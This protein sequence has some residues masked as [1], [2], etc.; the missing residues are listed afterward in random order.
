MIEGIHVLENI[1]S[2]GKQDILE[3]Y[4]KGTTVKWK[5]VNNL[6]YFK[7]VKSPQSVI[8]SD[9]IKNKVIIN[10]IE[11]IKNNA[12]VRLGLKELQSYRAKVNKLTANKQYSQFNNKVSMHIDRDIKHVS[13]VYYISNAD[14]DTKFYNLLNGNIQNFVEYVKNKEFNRFQEIRAITP[15]KGSI[16]IFDGYTPHHS[17]YPTVTDRYVINYNVVPDLTSKTLI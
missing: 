13:M 17:S 6:W 8:I 11:E 3:N 16:V 1:I 4:F 5:E 15:N 12:L 14:G 9:E 7:D 2:I 10:L